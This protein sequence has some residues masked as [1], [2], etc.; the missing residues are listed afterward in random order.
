MKK[1][2]KIILIIILILFVINISLFISNKENNKLNNFTTDWC[3]YFPNWTFYNKDIWF[4]C[5][6]EHDKTY[7]DWWTKNQKNKADLELKECVSK[8]WFPIIWNLMEIW[9]KIWGIPY[10]PTSFRWW[11]WWEKFRNYQ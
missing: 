1:I 8:K 2:I 6:T 9:V 11:Y 5:C 7:W 3:S 10:L 4:E